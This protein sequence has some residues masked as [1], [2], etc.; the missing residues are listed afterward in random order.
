MSTRDEITTALAE[1]RE[2][3]ERWFGALSPDEMTRPATASEVE[4][5]EMWTPKDHLAHIVGTERFFQGAIKRALGGAE[6]PLGFFTQ[7]GSDD[8]SARRNLINRANQQ[9][10]AKYHDEAAETLF[11]RLGETRQTTLA[12]LSGIDDARIAQFIPHSPFG[13]QTLGALFMTIAQ[14]AGL[15]LGWLDRALAARDS[16]SR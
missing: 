16:Q 4:D 5:G 7:V 8:T 6:D 15:H 10:V 14:H 9:A 12:L 2:R 3:V 13:D 11:S 1:Q